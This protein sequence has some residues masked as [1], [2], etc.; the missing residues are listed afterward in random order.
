MR[1]RSWRK[2]RS[3]SASPQITKATIGKQFKHNSNNSNTSRMKSLCTL[4][5]H[6]CEGF[7]RSFWSFSIGNKNQRS[8]EECSNLQPRYWGKTGRGTE[9]NIEIHWDTV[10]A[11]TRKCHLL[12][13]L[14]LW[15]SNGSWTSH[16]SRPRSRRPANALGG[17]KLPRHLFLAQDE[18]GNSMAGTFAIV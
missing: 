5:K 3:N 14:P 1:E 10:G 16:C 13:L 7:Y 9:S 6:P 2:Q 18:T 15:Q 12:R 17:L 11:A 8:G 4:L